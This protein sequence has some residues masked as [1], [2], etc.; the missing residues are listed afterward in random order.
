M[1]EQICA[2][3]QNAVHFMSVK[4]LCYNVWGMAYRRYR[5]GF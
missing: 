2:L 5:D 3:T 4:A 1:L